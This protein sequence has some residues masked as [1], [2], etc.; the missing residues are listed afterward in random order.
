M[1]LVAQ[2]HQGAI[3]LGVIEVD[4]LALRIIHLDHGPGIGAQRGIVAEK[5]GVSDEAPAK[6][7]ET[8][9]LAGNNPFEDGRKIV[10][11]VNLVDGN[12]I[13]A[14][15][16]GLDVD[17]EAL[18]KE[19]LHRDA[20]E[21]AVDG[22]D[23]KQVL[24]HCGTEF[25]NVGQQVIERQEVALGDVAIDVVGPG[26]GHGDIEWF[27]RGHDQRHALVVVRRRNG[28]QVEV[29]ADLLLKDRVHGCHDIGNALGGP[30]AGATEGH[31]HAQGRHVLSSRDGGAG[32]HERS[33]R[34][35]Q[36]YCLLWFHCHFLLV[37]DDRAWADSGFRRGNAYLNAPSVAPRTRYFWKTRNSRA[38]GPVAITAMAMRTLCAGMDTPR[39]A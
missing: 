24:G 34:R 33:D 32:K 3:F 28:D 35:Q 19:L 27:A 11:P 30:G 10:E 1:P 39:L 38:A 31:H 23:G 18:G 36:R 15:Q 2:A 12:V 21:R 9:A 4:D 14:D 8:L 22:A 17:A 26:R 7:V 20:I 37:D 6:R 13:L 29:S 16:V 5:F 25:R